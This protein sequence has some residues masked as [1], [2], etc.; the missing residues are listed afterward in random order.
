MSAATSGEAPSALSI[1]IAIARLAKDDDVSTA[2]GTADEISIELRALGWLRGASQLSLAR[3]DFV[4]D[5]YPWIE[6]VG[7]HNTPRYALTDY[8]LSRARSELKASRRW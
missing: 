2:A 1:A 6:R 3:D 5:S 4:R 8:G 7:H